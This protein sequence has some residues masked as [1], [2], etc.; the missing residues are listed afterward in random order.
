MALLDFNL[1]MLRDASTCPAMTSLKRSVSSMEN[2]QSWCEGGMKRVSRCYNLSQM[3]IPARGGEDDDDATNEDIQGTYPQTLDDDDDDDDMMYDSGLN[4]EGDTIASPEAGSQFPGPPPCV[5]GK[6]AFNADAGGTQTP[7]LSSPHL[8]RPKPPLT[9]RQSISVL[10]EYSEAD[11]SF[12]HTPKNS[13]A[14]STRPGGGLSQMF[15][16]SVSISGRNHSS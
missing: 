10:P 9:N 14:S 3:D 8:S 12:L 16:E 15:S 2:L 7:A 13:A 1:P 6:G 5:R 11:L 4:I